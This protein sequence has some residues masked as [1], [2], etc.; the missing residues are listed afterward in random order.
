M[1]AMADA[2]EPYGLVSEISTRHDL[3]PPSLPPPLTVVDPITVWTSLD[4]TGKTTKTLLVGEQIY[5]II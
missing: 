2:M 3:G 4:M 1:L 5:V